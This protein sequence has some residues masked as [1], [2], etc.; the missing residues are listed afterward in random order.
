MAQVK[1]FQPGGK[2]TISGK[3]YTIDQ[4][5]EYM[6]S[7]GFSS[8]ER[9]ALAGT[10]QSIAGGA[11]RTF[12]RNANSI[13]G[14]GVTDD[15]TGFYGSEKKAERNQGKST[16]WANRQARRNSDHHIVNSAL[17]RLG[18]IEDYYNKKKE[19]ES[20]KTRL[21]KGSDANGFYT[22]DGRFLEG[23]ENSQN[24]TR[25]NAIFDALQSG[26]LSKYDLQD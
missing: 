21:Y 16:R 9:A 10:I 26:D 11:S 5:N 20:E 15:F 23:P 2:L 8:Q 13:S 6:N 18:G 12:D 3:D 14:E 17:E 7:G 24:I 25:I 19:K 22:S 1:K 4:L